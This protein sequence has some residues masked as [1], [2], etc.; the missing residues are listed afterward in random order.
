MV[1]PVR[2]V[3]GAVLMACG[4]LLLWNANNVSEVLKRRETRVEKHAA[5]H[6]ATRNAVAEVLGVPALY[7][8]LDDR[9]AK[10]VQRSCKT[11]EHVDRSA[12]EHPTAC[13][14]PP[15]P[16]E[17]AR[18]HEA[19]GCDVFTIPF[20]PGSDG[21]CVERMTDVEDWSLAAMPVLHEAR[22][23]KFYATSKAHPQL[24]YLIKPLCSGLGLE[25]MYEVAAFHADRVLGSNRVPPTALVHIPVSRLMEVAK[26]YDDRKDFIYSKFQQ[27]HIDK[28][29]RALVFSEWVQVYTVDEARRT[30]LAKQVGGEEVVPVS[31]QL[32]IPDVRQI[33]DSDVVHGGLLGTIRRPDV[34]LLDRDSWQMYLSPEEPYEEKHA[35]GMLWESEVALF[36]FILGNRDRSPVKNNFVVGGCT[37]HN[38]YA[39]PDGQCGPGPRRPG[40]PAFIALDHGKTFTKKIPLKH[41]RVTPLMFNTF[42]VF[43][44]A[45]LTRILA[46]E[47]GE[48]T[49]RMQRLLPS[50]PA[51]DLAI[52]DEVLAACEQRLSTIGVRYKACVAKYSVEKVVR[53]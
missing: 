9:I 42:C 8:G 21:R 30:G 39:K 7:E 52:T 50:D 22:A 15:L 13:R 28:G 36:D 49:R 35:I 20:A 37:H 5:K 17:W 43:E 4:L 41:P 3:G 45:S 48:F 34:D 40:P 47:P 14:G 44:R 25:P 10:T 2:V 24:K 23:V 46:F 31:V 11:D 26:Q 18:L 1:R 38:D 33:G 27:P 29:G 51:M 32:W 12:S 6:A 16:T 53:S 19:S